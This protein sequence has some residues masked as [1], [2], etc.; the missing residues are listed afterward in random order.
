MTTILI[1]VGAALVTGSSGSTVDK[2]MWMFT[3]AR[4]IT[5]V[6]VGGEYPASSVS[7]MEVADEGVMK[8]NRGPIFIMC[9]N[10]VLSFGGPLAILVFLIT[11]TAAGDKKDH[12]HYVW[13]ICAAF[14]IL[15]PLIVFYFRLKM[16]TSKL[17]REGAI[18]KRVPYMLVLRRYWRSLIG[19]AGAWFLYVS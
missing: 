19:T 5:G 16:V 11:I 8:R 3:V 17:Y 13:R 18:Q 4:G 9:T 6:G 15:L 14:G 2:M 10:F 1:V 12:L 7:A